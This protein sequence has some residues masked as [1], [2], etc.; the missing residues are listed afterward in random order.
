MDKKFNEECYVSKAWFIGVLWYIYHQFTVSCAC[1][2]ACVCACAFRQNTYPGQRL[3]FV[4]RLLRL[5]GAVLVTVSQKGTSWGKEEK[6]IYD[7]TLGPTVIHKISLLQTLLS[8]ALPLLFLFFC[9]NNRPCK[10]QIYI[11]L[12]LEPPIIFTG[13]YNGD[14]CSSD[15]DWCEWLVKVHLQ[16]DAIWCNISYGY[17]FK[18]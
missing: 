17:T 12:Y 11:H 7:M 9:S 5:Q 18:V 2:G 10:L 3:L 6:P 14:R 16:Y 4:E 1:K 13:Y 8:I 15:I